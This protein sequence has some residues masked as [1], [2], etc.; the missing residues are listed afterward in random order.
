MT[1]LMDVVGRSIAGRHADQTACSS[2]VVI[3]GGETAKADTFEY[4]AD[5]S[6]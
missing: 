5:R 6:L 1:P 2:I 4:K 3:H